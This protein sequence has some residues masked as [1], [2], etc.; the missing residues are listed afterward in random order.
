MNIETI[1]IEGVKGFAQGKRVM[2]LGNDESAEVVWVVRGNKT[3]LAGGTAF[4]TEGTPP[5][6]AAAA[7]T[8][9]GEEPC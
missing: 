6:C 2:R 4:K 8:N 7:N 9:A 5:D 1:Q 3:M